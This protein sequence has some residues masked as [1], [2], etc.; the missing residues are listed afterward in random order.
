M[1]KGVDVGNFFFEVISI[2]IIQSVVKK[3]DNNEKET[4]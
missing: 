4:I 1:K 2:V 3:G